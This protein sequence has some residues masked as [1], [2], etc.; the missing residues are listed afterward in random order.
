VSVVSWR[1]T[2]HDHRS[3]LRDLIRPIREVAS[4]VSASEGFGPNERFGSTAAAF[5]RW[6]CSYPQGLT[7]GAT[8][9]F[10][11]LAYAADASRSHRRAPWTPE[12]S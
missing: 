5:Q 11:L 1:S 10:I 12:V 9:M 8:R 2:W 4:S 7:Q 3:T 6:M